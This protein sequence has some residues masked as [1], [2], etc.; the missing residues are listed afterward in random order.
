[1]L[2]KEDWMEIKAKVEHG[3]YVKDIAAELGVHPKTVSRALKRGG[4]P[5][6]KRPGA[7]GSMLD[8]FKPAIDEMLKAGVWNGAVI[9]RKLEE[10][11]YRGKT[12]IIRDYIR[13]KRP[14][15]ESRATVRFET[16]PGEQ[17]QSDWGEIEAVVAGEAQK[18]CFSVSTLGFSRRFHFWCTNALDAEHTYEGII[19]AFEHFGG[20]TKEVLVDNQKTAVIRNRIGERVQFNER[21]LDLAG[22]Y[23]FNPRACRPY[24]ARTKGK[25]ERMVGYIKHNFFVRYSAFESISHMNA[26]AEEWLRSEADPRMHGSLKEV[27]SERFERERPSLLALP[28]LRYDTSYLEQR[29]VHWD[30]YVEVRGNRYSVPSS[31]CGS[32]VQVRIGLEGELRI[33]SGD[34][35][36]AEH[37]LRDPGDGWVTIASH[38]APL[39]QKAL[40]V[41]CRDLSVYE[42]VSRCS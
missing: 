38:H 27:V 26:L 16:E 32:M 6:G 19:R 12:T 35:L 39:W 36:V 8:S 10:M 28:R 24:R 17:M 1:M 23:G 7:R 9:L 37:L 21:F 2:K 34:E 4:T 25:D 22:R 5:S 30:G 31:F 15:R 41:E 29:F 13:P 42:E 20:V 3:V 11:G 18:I 40:S 33:L 14:M